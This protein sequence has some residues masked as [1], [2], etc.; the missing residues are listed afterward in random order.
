MYI[1]KPNN[2][3]RDARIY[4]HATDTCYGFAVRYD[5]KQAINILQDIKQRDSNK[6]FSLLFSDIAMLEEYCILTEKQKIYIMQ[7]QPPISFIVTKKE[8]LQKIY[9]PKEKTL[10]ARIEHVDFPMRL[11]TYLQTPVTT[12]SVN[13]SGQKPLYNP[14]AIQ[15]IFFN[16]SDEVALI[17]S[18]VLPYRKPSAIWD[19]TQN[20]PKQLR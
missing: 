18:G 17:N 2:I 11:A 12:T 19:I 14:H 13:I 3:P 7:K 10:S 16:T 5:D 4:I 9:F 6:P 20:P 1:I 8:K 15:Q